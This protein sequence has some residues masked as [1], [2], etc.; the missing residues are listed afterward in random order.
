[1]KKSKK[2]HITVHY[3]DIPWYEWIYQVSSIWEIISLPDRWSK[4]LKVLK[5]YCYMTGWNYHVWLS[6]N[7]KRKRVKVCYE[8][9]KAFVKNP[10]WYIYVWHTDGNKKNNN[11]ENLFWTNKDN[12]RRTYRAKDTT[13]LFAFAE[14]YATLKNRKLKTTEEW[15]NEFVIKNKSNNF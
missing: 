6:E 11:Y 2:Q 8:V 13:R 1:M 12:H 14:W 15:Y 5:P 3:K 9:A 7:W 10:N 4:R